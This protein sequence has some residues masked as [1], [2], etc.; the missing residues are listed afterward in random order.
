MRPLACSLVVLGL[1]VASGHHA[2]AQ[3]APDKIAW[4]ASLDEA[5][6]QA[7]EAKRPLMLSV[8]AGPEEDRTAFLKSL[9]DAKVRALSLTVTCIAACEGSH[10][11]SG[12][13]PCPVFQGLTCA[14]HAEAYAALAQRKMLPGTR[15]VAQHIFLSPL[16]KALFKRG[17]GFA[18]DEGEHSLARRMNLA[19]ETVDKAQMDAEI[20]EAERFRMEVLLQR[21]RDRDPEGRR[22]ASAVLGNSDDTTALRAVSAA[23]RGTTNDDDRALLYEALGVRGNWSALALCAGGLADRDVAVRLAAVGAIEKVDMPEAAPALLAQCQKDGALLPAAMSIKGACF[24]DPQDKRVMADALKHSG[25]SRVAIR[26]GACWGMSKIVGS[27]P[28]IARLRSMLGSDKEV[29]AR[30]AAAWALGVLGESSDASAIA[31]QLEKEKNAPELPKEVMGAAIERLN[32]STRGDY[33]ELIER[34]L[35]IEAYDDLKDGGDNNNKGK[36]GKWGKYGGGG[37]APGGAG[38]TGGKGGKGWGG[39]WGGKGGGKKG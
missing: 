33:D 14:Q 8:L 27:D 3:D 7:K 38:G 32:G 15:R 21:V 16:G 24:L 20:A 9:D 31:K 25:H 28:V 19:V 29:N 6:V 36:W 18:G 13:D 1:G 22:A 35:A 2:V 26:I 30:A 10:A 23:V 39:G 17:F 5:L 4:V 12:A 34:L 11:P 37:G